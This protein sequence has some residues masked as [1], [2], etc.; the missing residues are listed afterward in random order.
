MTLTPHT[1]LDWT[2][3]GILSEVHWCIRCQKN[4]PAR[5]ETYSS[6]IGKYKVVYCEV[7]G[8]TLQVVSHCK[9]KES[10]ND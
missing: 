10:S 1:K 2:L 9:K 5:V 6:L 4:Q 7:C 3:R 8:L